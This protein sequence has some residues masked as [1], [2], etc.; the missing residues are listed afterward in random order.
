MKTILTLIATTLFALTGFSQ[1]QYDKMYSSE[2]AD[3]S[4]SYFMISETGAVVMAHSAEGS[5]QVKTWFES[6]EA[7]S[8]LAKAQGKIKEGTKASFVIT[9]DGKKS[10]CIATGNGETV[11][12][13]IMAPGS[14]KQ[15][16]T[17][18]LIK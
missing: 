14:G 2:M 16:L 10:N 12:M 6:K 15:D 9:L 3:G 8:S 1:F 5:A 18:K 17:F 13:M 7:H 4:H 11:A